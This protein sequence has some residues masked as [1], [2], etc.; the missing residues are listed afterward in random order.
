MSCRYRH[1][2]A[3]D[4]DADLRERAVRYAMFQIELDHDPRPSLLRHDLFGPVDGRGDSGGDEASPWAG[5][6]TT[7]ST[8]LER[9]DEV[10]ATMERCWG[11][12]A[13]RC[14]SIPIC[15]CGSIASAKN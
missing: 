10:A 5:A 4:Q 13:C 11:S 8:C 2:P 14:W 12:I 3:L 15:G 1:I 9:L 7:T 6:M